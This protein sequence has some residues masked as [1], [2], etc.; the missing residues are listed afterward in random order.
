MAYD[1]AFYNILLNV[2]TSTPMVF[3]NTIANFCTNKVP[4]TSCTAA[5]I[6]AFPAFTM[7]SNPTGDVIRSAFGGQLVKNFFDPRL[8]SRTITS[9][10]FHSPYSEQWSFGLQRQ[11][12]R[13]HVIEARYVGNHGVGLFQTLN[14]NPF[15]GADTVG[16]S[17]ACN[18]LFTNGGVTRGFCSAGAGS[19]AFLFP[20]LVLV[21]LLFT[22]QLTFSL[23]PLY[24]G[25]LV[26]SALAVWQVTGDGEASAFEGWALVGTYAILATFTL[27]E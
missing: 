21:S 10:D 13:N 9:N 26:L 2:S 4:A 18:G 23:A 12:S 15:L 1:P 22:T 5:D 27:Y 19:T 7:P 24:I 8:L 20:A 17:G 6:V 11:V 14:R 3:N 25:A 16:T